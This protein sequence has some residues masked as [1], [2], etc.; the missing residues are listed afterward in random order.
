MVSLQ[1]RG[2]ALQIP[3]DVTERRVCQQ[4]SPFVEELIS[5]ALVDQSGQSA[6]ARAVI[7]ADQEAAFHHNGTIQFFGDIFDG[8]PI[9]IS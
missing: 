1:C 7:C 5:N 4:I 3:G 8:G 6:P 9:Y 2:P